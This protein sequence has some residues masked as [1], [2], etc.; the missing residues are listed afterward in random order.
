MK[1]YI[2]NLDKD[3]PKLKHMKYQLDFLKLDYERIP[4]IS[5]YDY[6]LQ[7]EN[8]DQSVNQDK[9]SETNLLQNINTKYINII[10]VSTTGGMP[11]FRRSIFCIKIY[12][13]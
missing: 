9:V 6:I 3:E 10:C 7:N 1:T 13:K 5:K 12:K 11:N 4:G 2:I 8:G